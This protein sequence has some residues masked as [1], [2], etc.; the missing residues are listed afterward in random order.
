VPTSDEIAEGGAALLIHLAETPDF[1]TDLGAVNTSASALDLLVN[2]HD[3]AGAVLGSLP[4]Q[5]QPYGHDQ[6]DGAFA[7]AGHPN[8]PDGFATV[9][10]TTPGGRFIAYA[11]VTDLRTLD[12]FHVPM[13]PVAWLIFSDG[14][15]TGTTGRWSSTSP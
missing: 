1:Q 12:A 14:F 15:E 4:L 7:A 6:I 10:T 5:L 11:T 13:S 2:L 3:A 9:H 8:V